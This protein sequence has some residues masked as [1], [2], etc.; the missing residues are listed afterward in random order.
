MAA[1]L[2]TRRLNRATMARQLLLERHDLDVVEGLRRVAALQAQEPASPYVALWNRIDG[3]DP[4]QL[5][6]AFADR[7]LIKASLMR[8]TL[9]AVT[10]DDYPAFH[11]AM[12]DTLRASRL[13]DKRFRDT[14]LSIEEA[15]AL[16]PKLLRYVL[17][18][19][20]KDDIEAWLEQRLGRPPPARLWWALRHRLLLAELCVD[21]IDDLANL[22]R[23]FLQ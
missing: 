2:T 11:A 3:F 21:L 13:N 20:S 22:R 19:R 17:R 18:P 14:G 16:I 15:D 8:I 9:H 23:P 1:A 6:E 12:L 7:A 5:D 10:A 4:S